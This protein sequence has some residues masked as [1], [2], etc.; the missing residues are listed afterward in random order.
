MSG[1][2]RGS[3]VAVRRALQ[4]L[5]A[6]ALPVAVLRATPAAGQDPEPGDLRLEGELNSNSFQPTSKDAQ[7]SLREGD[8]AW[9]RA[10]LGGAG[11]SED[12]VRA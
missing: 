5:L 9:A 8:R 12:R 7:T 11:A 10:A 2:V 3:P 1:S 6:L 4:L